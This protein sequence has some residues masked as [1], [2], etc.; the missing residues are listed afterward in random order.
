MPYNVLPTGARRRTENQFVVKDRNFVRMLKELMHRR[1]YCPA[2]WL[3][4]VGS[5]R[6]LIENRRRLR[7]AVFC[8]GGAS[9]LLAAGHSITLFHFLRI[10]PT[11]KDIGDVYI[12]L[13]NSVNHFIVTFH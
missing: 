6:H 11:V 3:R 10:L 2:D 1:H 13:N 7:E 9:W 5:G 4:L 8:P 12:V